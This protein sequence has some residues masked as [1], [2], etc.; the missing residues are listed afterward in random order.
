MRLARLQA[1][2]TLALALLA[3]PPV[4]DAQAGKVI[5]IGSLELASP[6]ASVRGHKAL[7]QGLRELALR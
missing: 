2:A 6:S 5:R 1:L 3:S 7:Q 4:A